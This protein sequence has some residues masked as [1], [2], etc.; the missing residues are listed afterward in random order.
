MKASRCPAYAVRNVTR[1]VRAST[2]SDLLEVG[3]EAPPVE[4][5]RLRVDER[6]ER[7]LHVVRRDGRSVLPARP[8]A[9][10]HRVDEAA[11]VRLDRLGE[12]RHEVQVLVVVEEVPLQEGDDDVLGIRRRD[13]GVQRLGLPLEPPVEH[14]F[15]VLARPGRRR[16][17]RGGTPGRRGSSLTGTPRGTRPRPRRSCPRRRRRGSRGTRGRRGLGTESVSSSSFP[18]SAPSAAARGRQRSAE[19]VPSART[20]GESA[21][22]ALTRRTT[23]SPSSFRSTTVRTGGVPSTTA[24]SLSSV[25]DSASP[26]AFEARSEAVTRKR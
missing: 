5:R 22:A 12:A 10:L 21:S 9:E 24:T 25:A 1:A 19:T 14:A 16:R 23:R 13:E 3:E 11:R 17:R 6:L 18:S 26:S 15:L 7:R 2:T 4:G 20:T 8:V